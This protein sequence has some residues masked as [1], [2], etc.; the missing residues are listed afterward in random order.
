MKCY[1]YFLY[2]IKWNKFYVGIS[3][4]VKD[5]LRRHNSAQSLSTKGGIPWEIIHAI[6][7]DNK[8]SAM[9]LETKVKKRGIYRF[10]AD[11]NLL[12]GFSVPP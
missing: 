5:R 9:L 7:C 12:Q 3:N 2:S 8:S 11:N 10:L 6:E 1:V 4:D